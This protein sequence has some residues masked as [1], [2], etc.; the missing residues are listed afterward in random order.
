VIIEA[1][2]YD[3]GRTRFV[4]RPYRCAASYEL[5]AFTSSEF[6]L[7]V[8]RRRRAPLAHGIYNSEERAKKGGLWFSDNAVR[9]VIP[10]PLEL[11]PP[12]RSLRQLRR[13]RKQLGSINVAFTST[14]L[15]WRGYFSV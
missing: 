9:I 15:A 8:R 12:L 13:P 1:S 3:S 10:V 14:I 4:K 6:A 5:S 7:A 2:A 11:L